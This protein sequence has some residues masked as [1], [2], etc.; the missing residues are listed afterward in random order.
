MRYRPGLQRGRGASRD[1]DP[2]YYRPNLPSAGRGPYESGELGEDDGEEEEGGCGCGCAIIFLIL[3]AV[4]VVLVMFFDWAPWE[5]LGWDPPWEY[6]GRWL[7]D[8]VE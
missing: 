5:Y 7:S 6:V 3:I 1:D 8:F 4:V 2:R